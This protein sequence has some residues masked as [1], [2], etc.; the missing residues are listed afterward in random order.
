M[1]SLLLSQVGG[2]KFG[3]VIISKDKEHL[4]LDRSHCPHMLSQSL[5]RTDLD[6]Q[7]EA[8]QREQSLHPFKDPELCW[9]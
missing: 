7:E 9:F 2:W 4:A 5:A 3:F 6:S 1:D 8:V